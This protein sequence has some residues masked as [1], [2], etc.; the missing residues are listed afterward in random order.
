MTIK[1]ANRFVR[2][3]HRHSK[4]VTGALWATA[5]EEA[6]EIVGV[7]IVGRPVARKLQDG[8]IAEAKVA[9]L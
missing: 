6:G 5:A 9:E 3:H 4:P 7:G 1:D 8:R 2:L